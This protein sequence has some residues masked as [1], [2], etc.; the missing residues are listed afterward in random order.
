MKS[1]TVINRLF[2]LTTTL[3]IAS[4]TLAGEPG[5]PRE[6][7]ETSESDSELNGFHAEYKLKYS[8]F[9]GTVV[10]DLQ[11]T[12][13]PDEYLYEVTTRAGGLARIA[14]SGDAKERSRFIY[15]DGAV[16]PMHYYLNDGR[17]NDDSETDI[18]FDWSSGIAHTQHEGQTTERT[19]EPETI[20]RLSTDV[21][22]IV[23]LRAGRVPGEYSI[24]DDDS[25]KIYGYE[26]LGEETIKVPAGEFQTLKFNRQRP[27]S[28]RS[29]LIWFAPDAGYLPVRTEYLKRGKTTITST[30]TVL[31]LK[32]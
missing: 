17:N 23:E 9:S 7:N 22:A 27:G 4:L 8:M 5:E 3:L 21:T 29:M 18:R 13:K 15:T 25:I 6:P 20:D 19:L 31:N 26:F 12:E 30:A 2:V 14:L 10:L 11:A 24:I 16:K 28:S 32:P 1:D